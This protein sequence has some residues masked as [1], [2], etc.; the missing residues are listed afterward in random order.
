MKHT[1]SGSYGSIRL[2]PMSLEQSQEYRQMR[3]KP[4][5]RDYFINTGE[6]S[7]E[8][9]AAWYRE[10][11]NRPG[12]YLFAVCHKSVYFIGGCGIYHVNETYREA[13]FGRI[14]IDKRWSGK[15]CGYRTVMAAC[16]IAEMNLKLKRLVLHVREE[17]IP[18]F[19]IYKKAGF[20]VI[21]NSRKGILEMEKKLCCDRK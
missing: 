3:N 13:E 17:N 11:V 20:A 5:N 10:Y 1:Y 18:A 16:G 19:K 7:Q 8:E 4:E 21:G 15:G 14:L 12:D 2:I 9:Q 6:I